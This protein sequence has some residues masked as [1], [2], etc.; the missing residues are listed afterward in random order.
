VVT[1]ATE[2]NRAVFLDRDGVLVVPEMRDGRSFAP[3]SLEAFSLYPDAAASLARLKAAG[4]LLVAVTNQPDIGNGLVSIDTVNEMHRLMSQALPID[5]IEMC[6]HSQSE[7]CDCRKPKPGMLINAARHCGIDLA[8]SVM[9]GD[10]SSDV[11][12]GRAAGCKTVFIDLGYASEL[13]PAAPDFT[14][15]SIAEAADV[16]LGAMP[17]K[18]ECGCVA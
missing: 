5:R 7:V 4:Y 14:V 3:R 8:G 2:S 18:G 6:P 13:K 10:R 17:T 16:I 9:V 12:A 15:R 11:E 1:R